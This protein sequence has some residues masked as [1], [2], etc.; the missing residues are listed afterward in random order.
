MAQP[1]TVLWI[2][3]VESLV[4]EVASA[5][6]IVVCDGA[7]CATTDLADRIACEHCDTEGLVSSSGIPS[8]GCGASGL[9]LGAGTVWTAA[10]RRGLTAVKARAQCHVC[11]HTAGPDSAPR[12]RHHTGHTSTGRA[13]L[14]P[15]VVGLATHDPQ[16]VVV[17]GPGRHEEGKGKAPAL[18]SGLRFRERQT[19]GIDSNRTLDHR[20]TV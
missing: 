13:L 17:V 10:R 16:G 18:G 11:P 4:H 5:G 7:R 20:L 19:P 2:V 12:R 3:R 1:A 15:R 14:T 6:R 9:V 8:L